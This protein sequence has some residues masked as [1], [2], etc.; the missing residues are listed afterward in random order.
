VNPFLTITAGQHSYQLV[1]FYVSWS[2][3]VTTKVTSYLA[4][5]LLCI[6]NLNRGGH[7]AAFTNQTIYLFL[8]LVYM[9]SHS[10]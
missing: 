7:R 8:V 6:L 1:F 10:Y 9:M 2:V 5:A 4:E 3:L